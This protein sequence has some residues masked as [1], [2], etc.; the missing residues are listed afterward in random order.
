MENL[1]KIYVREKKKIEIKWFL[2]SKQKVK[3]SLYEWQKTKP[4]Q[5]GTAFRNTV[6]S[7]FCYN[8]DEQKGMKTF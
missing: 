2:A 6:S 1:L 3:Y 8:I 7:K 4:T 5:T